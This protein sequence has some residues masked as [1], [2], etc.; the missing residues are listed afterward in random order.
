MERGHFEMWKA[1]SIQHTK[2][3]F[4][5]ER[6]DTLVDQMAQAQYVQ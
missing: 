6:L 4:W 2:Q 5:R 3:D 1:Y